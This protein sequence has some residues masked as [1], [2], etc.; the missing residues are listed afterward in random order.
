MNWK[1]PTSSEILSVSWSIN[2]VKYAKIQVSS[3]PILPLYGKMRVGE[4]LYFGK[5]YSVILIETSRKFL[6]VFLCQFF[7]ISRTVLAG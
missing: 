2:F 1:L 5:L 6:N 7:L 3:D 4:N